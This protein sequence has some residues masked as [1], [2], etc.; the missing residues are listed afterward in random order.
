MVSV[1]GYGGDVMLKSDSHLRT[2]SGIAGL[3]A[4]CHVQTRS[5]TI[6]ECWC[7]AAPQPLH[8]SSQ[9]RS[10]ARCAP[11]D[12]AGA[13]PSQPRDRERAAS[14]RVPLPP[15]ADSSTARAATDANDDVSG[16]ADE[17][18]PASDLQAPPPLPVVLANDVQG[19]DDV[20]RKDLTFS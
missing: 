19:R 3:V 11:R 12:A 5:G 7:A 10:S 4:D 17:D 2:R 16:V 6:A 8:L 18:D 20:S 14:A 13:V 9:L 1:R 15:A